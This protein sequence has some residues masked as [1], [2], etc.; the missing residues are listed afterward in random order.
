ML[1]PGQHPDQPCS[2][3]GG[4]VG[5]LATGRPVSRV[6]GKRT[7]V[8]LVERYRHPCETRVRVSHMKRGCMRSQS[9]PRRSGSVHLSQATT[10]DMEPAHEAT[11]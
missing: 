10:Q 5:L 4:A 6:T 1:S 9:A 3:Q 7:G 8:S 2:P 11:F